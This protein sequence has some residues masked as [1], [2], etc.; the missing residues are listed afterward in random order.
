ME[1]LEENEEARRLAAEMMIDEDEVEAAG[2]FLDPEGQ[3]EIEDNRMDDINPDEDFAH[4]DP[5]YVE[6]PD[7]NAFEKEYRPIEVRDLASIRRDARRLDNFQRKVVEIAVRH[8]RA[9]I[10]ARGGKNRL[11]IPPLVMVSFNY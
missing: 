1:F 8:A 2:D 10:K 3:Q 5:D 6:G 11:P 9:L 4:L 7:E